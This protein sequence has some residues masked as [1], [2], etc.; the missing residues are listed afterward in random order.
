MN[1][2]PAVLHA[3]IERRDL[4]HKWRWRSTRSRNVLIPVPGT[5]DAA[6]EDFAFA[7]RA[8]LVLAYVRN[9]GNFAIVLEDG[10]AFSRQTDDPG[11]AFWDIGN[12]A[13]MDKTRVC[14]GSI[15]G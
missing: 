11:A 1:E 12:R 8:I 15:L 3:H 5:G 2:H 9:G 14:D 4:L 6:V 13:R 7:E 10:D